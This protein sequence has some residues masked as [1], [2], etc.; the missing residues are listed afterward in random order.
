MIQP[1]FDLL[2]SDSVRAFNLDV[3]RILALVAQALVRRIRLAVTAQVARLAAWWRH[4]SQQGEQ[5]KTVSLGPSR[6]MRRA[7]GA[8]LH[9]QL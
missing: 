6:S 7:K 5:S 4:A 1:G 2:G 9:V 3:A 8:T